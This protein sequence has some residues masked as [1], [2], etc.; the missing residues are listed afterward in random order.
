LIN[1][2]VDASRLSAVGKGKANPVIECSNK[3]RTD[4]IK[5]LEPNR[6]VEIEQISYERRVN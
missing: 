5:C 3:K 1:G 4:L 2:G 6:R